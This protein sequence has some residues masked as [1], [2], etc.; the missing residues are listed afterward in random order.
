MAIQDSDLLVLKKIDLLAA[1]QEFEDVISDLFLN[2]AHRLK[3]TIKLKRRCK[4]FYK[5][6]RKQQENQEIGEG[7]NGLNLGHTIYDDSSRKESKPR[8]LL[9][10]NKLSMF[11]SSSTTKKTENYKNAFLNDL[12]K[13]MGT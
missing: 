6:L 10:L 13:K 1:D 7:K 2:A 3:R 8:M 5:N 4:A 9:S 12:K 11:N